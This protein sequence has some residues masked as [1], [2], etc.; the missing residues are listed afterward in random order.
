[1][2][3]W[4]KEAA[5]HWTIQ[6]KKETAPGTGLGAGGGGVLKSLCVFKWQ[7]LELAPATAD[8]DVC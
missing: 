3:M 4:G 6:A 1:M 7:P 8:F 5:P 2:D